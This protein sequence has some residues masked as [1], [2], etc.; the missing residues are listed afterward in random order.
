M[1][2]SLLNTMDWLAPLARIQRE[3]VYSLVS[4]AGSVRVTQ[5]SHQTNTAYK[6]IPPKGVHVMVPKSVFAA[7][8]V[9]AISRQT[10][11]GS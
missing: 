1:T 6:F 10:R 4:V 2:A 3:D 9:A 11:T 5:Y 7:D 8:Q